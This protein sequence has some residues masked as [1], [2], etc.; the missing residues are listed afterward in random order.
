MAESDFSIKATISA[1]TSNFEKGVKN[2]GNAMKSTSKDVDALSSK[3]SKAFTALGGLFAV[4]KI[5]QFGSE[6]VKAFKYQEKQ[7]KLLES[8]IKV[9][10]AAAWTSSKE[11]KSFASSLQQVTNYSDETIV[12]MQNVLLG[13]K[14]IKGDNFKEATKAILDMSTVMGMDLTSAAQA[15]GKALDDPIKGINSLTRQGF[16]FSDSQKKM[17][18]NLVDTGKTAEAQKIILNELAT[19]YGGASEATAD[20]G[21]QL[22]NTWGDVKEQIGGAIA[23]ISD[24]F[25]KFIKDFLDA[26]LNMNEHTKR[27]ISTFAKTALALGGLTTAVYV[28]K[29][30]LD[31]LKAHP[32]IA[33]L[34]V[35]ISGV[36][37]LVG[38]FSTVSNELEDESDEIKRLNNNAQGLFS[39]INAESKLTA[40]QINELVKLYPELTGRIKENNT[41]LEEAKALQKEV[42]ESRIW[43]LYHKQ[44]EELAKLDEAYDKINEKLSDQIYNLEFAKKWDYD[45]VAIKMYEDAVEDAT[46]SLKEK[47]DEITRYIL[48]IN[49]TLESIGYQLD[50]ETRKLIK[51]EVEV[52]EESLN[53]S[54]KTTESSVKSWREWLAKALDVDEFEF[55]KGKDAV[56]LYKNRLVKTLQ[57]GEAISKALGVSFSKTEFLERQLNEIHDKIVELLGINPDEIDEPFEIEELSKEN[58]ALAELVKTYKGLQLQYVDSEIDGIT[59]SI[60]D[61]TMS[62][63]DLYLT[64]LRTKGATDEQIENARKLLRVRRERQALDE[65]YLTDLETLDDYESRLL[66]QKIDREED[67]TEEYNRLSLEKI[68]RERDVALSGAKNAETRAKIN[69]YYDNEI[70]KKSKENAEKRKKHSLEVAKAFVGHLKSIA[71]AFTSTFNKMYS[72]SKKVVGGIVNTFKSMAEKIKN[73]F[74]GV[75]GI[76]SSLFDID[77]DESLDNILAFEDK[78]LTFFVETLP[79]L[80]GFLSSVFESIIVLIGNIINSIDAS[81]FVKILQNIVNI[82]IENVPKIIPQLSNLLMTIFESLGKIIVDNADTIVKSIGEIILA[83]ARN[84]PTII[85]TLIEVILKIVDAVASFLFDNADEFGNILSRT[86]N[87]LIQKI[88]DWIQNGGWK[89]LLQAILKIQKMLE[90]VVKDNI[91][92][93]VNTILDALPDLVN[94]LVDSIVSASETLQKLAKPLIRLISGIIMALIDVIASEEVMNA[95]A[96][97]IGALIEAIIEELVTNGS[98][99]LAKITKLSTNFAGFIPKL[100]M[101]IVQGIVGGLANALFKKETWTNVWDAIVSGFDTFGGAISLGWDFLKG[102]IYGIKDGISWAWGKI[103]GF[104]S[105]LWDKI[106]GFFGVHSPSKLFAGLGTNLI[107]GLWNGIKGAGSWLWDNLSSFFSQVWDGIKSIFSNV[108]S[109]FSDVFSDAWSGIKSAWSSAKD[110]FSDM[111]NSIGD[112]FSDCWDGIKDGW[113]SLC[114]YI[115]EGYKNVKSWFEDVGDSVGGI[116]GSKGGDI[117]L[118]VLTGGVSTLGHYFGWFANGTQNANRGLAVVG[119]QGPELVS[120]NGGERVLNAKNTQRALNTMG[121]NTNT[122][123]V[124]FYETRDTTAFAMLQ[125]LRDYNRRMAVN[126]IL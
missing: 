63:D 65:Q 104:F 126:G 31:A 124:N 86:I 75:V 42:E 87:N 17:L 15:V 83:V 96:E 37:A 71:N 90:Q 68:N 81:Q 25:L 77:L 34:S 109:W 36:S 100:I 106:C 4:N 102:L 118:G 121:G 94:F 48:Q 59:K 47:K 49:S 14:N 26:I 12:S 107:E 60:E 61:L 32:I 44:E 115:Y 57:E 45:N 18:K 40:N 98:T 91:D 116:T 119:E 20:I 54:T 46:E 108:G 70:E 93:L 38:L 110:W 101:N 120:F 66:D 2:A 7:L 24:G 113:S 6:S 53:K 123:N 74:D 1:N 50:E 125:Q 76:F 58:S 5:K 51:I 11:I 79:R 19:T 84:L 85:P 82:F 22:K 112:F 105:W 78:I 114:D 52:D 16:F 89:K 39:T 92:D 111:G 122:F 10:G 55:E 29:T 88:S 35:A 28:L 97:T 117:G 99:M 21:E 9:T 95:C 72:V 23:E 73:V 67:W 33:I 30:A 41:T 62:E 80:P 64:Q 103:K 3:I 43:D 56:K 27:F 69:E 8:T 13:F